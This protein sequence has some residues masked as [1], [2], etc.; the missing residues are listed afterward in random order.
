M[1]AVSPSLLLAL[2]IELISHILSFL[3]PTQLA[4][5]SQI[6]QLLRN[7][8]SDERLWSR[9]VLQNLPPDSQLEKPSPCKTWRELYAA[10]H[11]YWFLPKHR[12]WISDRA[13]GGGGVVMGAVV[14]VQYDP[15]RGCI[16]GYQLVAPRGDHPFHTWDYDHDV[17]IHTF[18]PE[19]FL[20]R[21]NPVIKLDLGNTCQGGRVQSETA[22]QC[23]QTDTV[24]SWVS[25]CRPI[26]PELQSP[27]M[28]LWPPRKLPA[29][30][31]VRSDSG[32]TFRDEGHRP[33]TWEEAS[34][35]AFRIRK[36]IGFQSRV[37]G[38][39]VQMGESVVTFSTLLPESYTPTASKPWQGLWVG[40]YSGHGCEFLLVM[41]KRVSTHA[42]CI[43]PS[44]W[45]P[46]EFEGLERSNMNDLDEEFQNNPNRD[47]PAETSPSP[48]PDH[49]RCQGAIDGSSS[50]QEEVAYHRLEA[51]KLTGDPNVPR[52]QYSWIAEDIGHDGLIRVANEDPFKGARIVKSF[53]HTAARGFRNGE[54][55]RPLSS[56]VRV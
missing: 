28:Q 53:G 26:P 6:C 54:W 10:H 39:P 15:R 45:R 30:Q 20:Y 1:A 41:Q 55:T 34:D 50:E 51:I 23:S 35:Q 36:G 37:L 4:K 8:A 13:L 46:E 14:M 3:S 16:E 24:R 48:P 31:R 12:I 5:T 27:S 33:K 42:P 18:D 25:L 43:H 29:K 21:E 11:P 17:I 49:E 56:A 7:L 38:I 32:S 2:P 19:V 52:G 40:D 9:F 44:S 47:E 22:M